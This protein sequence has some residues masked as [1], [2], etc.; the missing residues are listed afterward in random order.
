MTA[1]GQTGVA[2]L[3]TTAGGLKVADFDDEDGARWAALF[4][5]LDAV[6]ES[7]AALDRA[8]EIA[9]R[10]VAERGRLRLVDRLRPMLDAPA[11]EV[12]VG[13]TGHQPLRGRL[14]GLGADWMTLLGDAQ[15]WL[16]PLARVVWLRGP[17][18]ESAEPGS[19]G[20]L[21][22]R[23][24]FRLALR[25]L[26]RESAPLGVSTVSGDLVVGTITT[27]GHDHVEVQP[28]GAAAVL[29]PLEAIACIERR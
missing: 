22:A 19:E 13:T 10:V 29:V 5:D 7:D 26:L 2:S 21:A 20:V 12:V 4:G 6:W 15:E 16:V 3:W 8:A 25:R 28:G 11:S 1:S 14:T 24:T 17:G 18:P 23:L 27:V 9:D